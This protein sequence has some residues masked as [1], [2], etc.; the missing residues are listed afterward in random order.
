MANYVLSCCSTADLSKKHLENRDIRYIFFHY[1]LDGKEYLDDLGASMSLS[2]F[3]EEMKKG[4]KTR[5]SQINETEFEAYFEPFLMEGK[6][7]LHICLSSGITGVINSAYIAKRAL[8]TKY[9]ERK[10]LLVDSLSASSGYGLLVDKLADM[11]DEGRDIEELYDWAENNKLRLQHWFFT[12]DLTY[13]VRGGRV[14]KA[15]GIV[16]GLLN[17]NPLLKVNHKGQLVPFQKVRTKRKVIEAMVEQMVIHAEDGAKY[18]GK[19][20]ISHSACYADACMVADE[21][22]RRFPQL[23]GNVLIHNIGTTIGS[24]T[25]PGTVALFFWGDER[26]E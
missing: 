26:T 14:S 25:G 5:T 15:A 6:D 2:D 10:I 21:V 18:N 11:R 19:C 22:E 16:G 8:E 3:Y 23:S 13:L 20:Y 17:I 24:H 7:I 12:T 9:P 4:A 1:E